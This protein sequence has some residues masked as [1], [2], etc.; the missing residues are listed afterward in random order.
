MSKYTPR[1][2]SAAE[3]SSEIGIGVNRIHKIARAT[4]LGTMVGNTR[5]FTEMD[6]AALKR[7]RTVTGPLPNDG[8][9]S[10]AR[11]AQREREYARRKDWPPERVEAELARLA[12]VDRA[13]QDATLAS[14]IRN[15][16]PWEPWE[17]ELIMQHTGRA[18]AIHLGRTLQGVRGR[19][20]ILRKRGVQ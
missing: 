1:L 2:Y 13:A 10:T 19:R 4:G 5:V 11:K 18:V 15:G 16:E 7:R 9:L 6:I 14:A 17:D 12:G 3:V 8:R 20:K